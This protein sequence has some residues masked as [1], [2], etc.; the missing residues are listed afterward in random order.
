MRI[1]EIYVKGM[2]NCFDKKFTVTIQMT[3]L[4]LLSTLAVHFCI[5]AISAIIW[6]VSNYNETFNKPEYF[7]QSPNQSN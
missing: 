2:K 1:C 5:S 7:K 4:C 3:D 6:D